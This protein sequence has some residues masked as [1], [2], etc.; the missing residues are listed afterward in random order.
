MKEIQSVAGLLFSPDR[1]EVLL[2]ERRDVPV[3]VLPGGGVEKGEDPQYSIVR[4]FLEET[5]LKVEVDRLIGCYHPINR[6][7]KTTHLYE[8]RR[9]EGELSLSEETRNIAFFPLQGLPKLLPPP[10]RD[11]IEDGFL[12][13]PPIEKKLDS[14]TYLSLVKYFLSHPLLTSRFLLARLGIP[15]NR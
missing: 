9:I 6:L 4:E 7:T 10:Y 15:M 11:W 3:W 13:H 8:C 5:G 2:V 12:Y 1:T 14:I